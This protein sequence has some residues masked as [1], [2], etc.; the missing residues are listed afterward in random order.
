MYMRKFDERLTRTE[1]NSMAANLGAHSAI[2]GRR[3][4]PE[5]ASGMN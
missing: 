2:A 1:L 4:L 5:M 3:S